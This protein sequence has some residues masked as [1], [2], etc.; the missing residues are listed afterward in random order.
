MSDAR[1]VEISSK[2][3]DEILAAGAPESCSASRARSLASMSPMICSDL[4]SMLCFSASTLATR[5]RSSSSCPRRMAAS[6][7]SIA[8]SAKSS[9]MG[10]CAPSA[11]L[12]SAESRMSVFSIARA[13]MRSSSLWARARF[14]SSMSSTAARRLTTSSRR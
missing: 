4:I 9:P 5:A 7:W 2:P 10:P 3:C 12:E 11:A 1:S 8:S 13:T 14:S 6:R